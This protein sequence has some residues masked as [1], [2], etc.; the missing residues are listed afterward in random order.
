M[1]KRSLAI[2]I[3]VVV[4]AAGV[5]TVTTSRS[6]GEST[7]AQTTS[8][9]VTQAVTPVQNQASDQAYLADFKVGFGDGFS[10]GVSGFTYPEQS[11]LVGRTGGYLAGFEQGFTDGQNQQAMIQERLCTS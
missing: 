8:P 1:S 7:H 3:S 10:T 11:A 2:I 5:L 6:S 9:Y 4:F